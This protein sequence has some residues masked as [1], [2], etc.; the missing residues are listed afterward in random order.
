ME[1]EDNK[2]LDTLNTLTKDKE[3]YEEL[4]SKLAGQI[5]DLEA[6]TD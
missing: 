2:L 4:F 5:G 6:A 3:N 1:D